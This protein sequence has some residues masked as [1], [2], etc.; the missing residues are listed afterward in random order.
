MNNSKTIRKNRRRRAKPLVID[1]SVPS[2]CQ[3]I[4]RFDNQPFCVGCYRNADEIRDWM[5]MSRQQKL[6][7]LEKIA[8]RKIKYGQ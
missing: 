4:C 6:E 2:P 5:I 7:I 3:A 1:R 8:I